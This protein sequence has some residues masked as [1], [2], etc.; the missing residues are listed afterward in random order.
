MEKY[1]VKEVASMSGV[2]IR[3]LHY[4]DQIGLLKPSSRTEANYRFYGESELLR[5]Q[6]I[7]FYKELDFPLKDIQAL[8]DDPDFDPVQALEKHKIALKAR[9]KRLSHLL[10]TIN[11]TI[12]HL[13]EGS[14]MS[15]PGM[16]YDGLPEEM[17]K[18][19]RE[20]AIEKYGKE[21]IEQSEKE[22]MKLGK[23]GFKKLQEEFE[24]LNQ[25]LFARREEDP[26]SD[27]VQALI[28][29]HYAFIRQFWGTSGKED[30]QFEAYAGLGDLY[31]AD[32]RFTMVDGNPQPDFAAFLQKSMRQF[33]DRQN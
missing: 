3:T 19:Y 18:A 16:L 12:N 13:K 27:E 28:Q 29:R 10:E 11:H 26:N 8:L 33:A 32:E 9:R 6:Q 7:L 17:G 21:A 20:E 31:V 5:L 14:I 30:K 22:L 15:N 25:E 4:Y 23:E 2:S 1:S 24:K